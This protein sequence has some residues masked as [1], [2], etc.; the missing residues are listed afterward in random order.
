MRFVCRYKTL[1]LEAEYGRPDATG[2]CVEDLGDL[3]Y[4]DVLVVEDQLEDFVLEGSFCREGEDAHVR[5]GSAHYDCG[6]GCAPIDVDAILQE[7]VHEVFIDLHQSTLDNLPVE[8]VN[9]YGALYVLLQPINNRAFVL[10][11]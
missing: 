1:L 11:S 3:G 8:K 4:G 7:D 9:L 5:D 6:G 10:Q 2:L